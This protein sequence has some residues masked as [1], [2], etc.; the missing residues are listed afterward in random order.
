MCPVPERLSPGKDFQTGQTLSTGSRVI[1][2]HLQVPCLSGCSTPWTCSLCSALGEAH[3]KPF[4][5]DTEMAAQDPCLGSFSFLQH[6][7]P[8]PCGP[9][10]PPHCCAW[11]AHF[12]WEPRCQRALQRHCSNIHRPQQRVAVIVASLKLMQM[13]RDFAHLMRKNIFVLMCL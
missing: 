6:F 1:L 12:Q 3:G 4:E 2:K 13:V 10:L 8:W 9:S 11:C 5:G 7:L